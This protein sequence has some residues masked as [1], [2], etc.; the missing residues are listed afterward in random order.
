MK[1]KGWHGTG[2][3]MGKYTRKKSLSNLDLSLS[4]KT[5]ESSEFL[6]IL[7]TG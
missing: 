2:V 7:I 6:R 5:I 1:R 4:V 3:F